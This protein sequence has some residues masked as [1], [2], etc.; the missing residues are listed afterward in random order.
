VSP[1]AYVSR[2][3]GLGP[4]VLVVHAVQVDRADIAMLA[5]SGIAV[6]HCP[7]SN[8]RL[9]CGV[10]PLAD[11]LAAGI[12]VGLGT[13]GLSSNDDLDMF[14]EMR[15]ALRVSRER[16]PRGAGSGVGTTGVAR[17]AA[18]G[19]GTAPLD[20]ETV[21]RMATLDGA[22]ALG[23]EH[24]IGSLEVGKR[25][26]VIALRL[27]AALGAAAQA[28]PAAGPTVVTAALVETVSAAD[29]QMTM[30]DGRVVYPG[31]PEP[32]DVTRRFAVVRAKLGLG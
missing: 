11:L 18:A 22:R 1:V 17:D 6:A 10:A 24:V 26:D 32:E 20:A 8:L 21:L 14:A 16:A 3:G 15:A 25:A 31:A 27:P 9:E 12:A 7:R 28:Q 4:E 2:S 30:V 29:V 19:T 13:D 23:L 5:E